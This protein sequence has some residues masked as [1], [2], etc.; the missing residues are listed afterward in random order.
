MFILSDRMPWFHYD[1]IV[2][3]IERYQPAC[4]VPPWISQSQSRGEEKEEEN[5]STEE[6]VS[7]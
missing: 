4:T 2:R 3:S 7:K 1:P 5:L 6:V